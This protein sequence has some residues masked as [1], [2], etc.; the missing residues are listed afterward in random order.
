MWSGCFVEL[1][2]DDRDM[3]EPTHEELARFYDHEA[4]R[5]IDAATYRLMW[6][7]FRVMMGM[8]EGRGRRILE[9]GAG[10]GDVVV[11]LSERGHTCYAMDISEVRLAKYKERA[12]AHRITQL[13]GS[14]EDH[15]PLEDASLDVVLCGEVM[16]HVPD[17]DRAF[18]E[19]RRVLR[20]GGQLIVSVPY[21]ESLKIATCP[22][23]GK[24]FELNGHLHTYDLSS[25]R[26]LFGHHGFEVVQTHIGHTKVSRVVWS[27][28]Q[29]GLSLFLC[30]VL[31]GLT[32]RA[33]R[34]SDTWLMM[35][36]VCKP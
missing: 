23:C 9:V 15:I 11:T 30:R 34:A 1:R 24:K 16:E 36:G 22:N 17:N 19:I 12:E 29:S 21:R 20:R 18:E 27:R 25:L 13:L 35:K 6:Y 2:K 10:D 7:R 31:D 28:W 3:T 4:V 5:S 14:V 26:S 33:Y 8:I 32:S